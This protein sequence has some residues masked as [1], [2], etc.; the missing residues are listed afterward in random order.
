MTSARATAVTGSGLMSGHEASTGYAASG[1]DP[2]SQ[3]QGTRPGDQGASWEPTS[4]TPPQDGLFGAV[5]VTLAVADLTVFAGA[6]AFLAAAA[7]PE[8]LG[9]TLPVAAILTGATIAGMSATAAMVNYDVT[10][11]DPNPEGALQK[12]G[13]SGIVS[14]VSTVILWGLKTF[15]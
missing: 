1:E 4:G 11:P 9:T 12:G 10:S 5:I 13:T 15:G 2:T 8:D 6:G 3:Q 7:A 14:I